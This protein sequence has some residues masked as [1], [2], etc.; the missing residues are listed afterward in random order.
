M[1]RE[2]LAQL[3]RKLL[4]TLQ[5]AIEENKNLREENEC[6]RTDIMIKGDEIEDLRNRLSL[7]EEEY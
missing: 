5:H 2:H 3:G 1:D 4:M 6:I 7:M